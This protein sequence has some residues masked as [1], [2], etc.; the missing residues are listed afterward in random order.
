MT[1]HGK[2]RSGIIEK[3]TVE[4]PSTP[5]GAI[6]SWKAAAI[7][8]VSPREALLEKLA[9]VED[10]AQAVAHEEGCK[11]SSTLDSIELTEVIDGETYKSKPKAG[12]EAQPGTLFHYAYLLEMQVN[13]VRQQVFHFEQDN[14]DE[15]DRQRFYKTVNAAIDMG[16]DLLF[17]TIKQR[18]VSILRGHESS[19]NHSGSKKKDQKRAVRQVEALVLQGM[20][21]NQAVEKI[22]DEFGVARSTLYKW[23]KNNPIN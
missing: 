10:T 16:L 21:K 20:S 15:S 9:E 4:Y 14:E 11:R 17:M 12:T 23:I 18:E 5:E 6:A 22:K 2:L 1:I 8:S 7:E 13:I 19:Y 3:T